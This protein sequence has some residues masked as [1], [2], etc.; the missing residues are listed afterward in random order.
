MSRRGA[1][2]ASV[3]FQG[4]AQAVEVSNLR[5]ALG[6]LVAA[7]DALHASDD[8]VRGNRVA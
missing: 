5:D 4:M 6:E 8:V 7:V 1:E 3:G 2:L